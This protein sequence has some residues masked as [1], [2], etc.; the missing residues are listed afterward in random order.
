M[1]K[2]TR[3]NSDGPPNAKVIAPDNSLADDNVGRDTDDVK[4]ANDNPSPSIAEDI[5]LT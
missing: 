4:I 2:T 1:S 3:F 5:K